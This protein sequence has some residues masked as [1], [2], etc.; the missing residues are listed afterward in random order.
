[1]NSIHV[2]KNKKKFFF[3]NKKKIIFNNI[4]ITSHWIFSLLV[5]KHLNAHD[6]YVE[7]MEQV[8]RIFL[9]QQLHEISKWERTPSYNNIHNN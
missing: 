8:M 6:D 7:L 3:C 1:M 4:K 9:E 5:E 2:H